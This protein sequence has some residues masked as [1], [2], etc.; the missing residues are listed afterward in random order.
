M[1]TVAIIPPGAWAQT[2]THVALCATTP[3]S[4]D[5]RNFLEIIH[6]PQPTLT[7]IVAAA[8]LTAGSQIYTKG[9]QCRGSGQRLPPI[10]MV[11]NSIF[12]PELV[13]F[14]SPF[15]HFFIRLLHIRS[16]R[17]C[18][19]LTLDGFRHVMVYR[20]QR[21][22]KMFRRAEAILLDVALTE[23]VSVD[24]IRSYSRTKNVAQARKIVIRRLRAETDLSWREIGLT[25]GRS[26][27]SFRG[28]ERPVPPH[29]T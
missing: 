9:E 23:G 27:T 22:C 10:F 25:L 16:D 28:S 24:L 3:G 26:S 19:A 12:A 18:T 4:R 20:G 17:L 13:T 6:S 7:L 14:P 5:H 11:Q 29:K 21:R 2:S 1:S 15:L 8:A